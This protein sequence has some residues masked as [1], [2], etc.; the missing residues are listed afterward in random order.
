M[1]S[2]SK[3]L[4]ILEQH[5]IQADD[6]T[7]YTDVQCDRTFWDR[8]LSAFDELNVFARTRK[9]RP[10]EDLSKLLISSRP[11]AHLFPMPDFR[12][13]GG[14]IK[15]H[16]KIKNALQ[17]ALQVSDA[18]IMRA[19]SPIS[20][21]VGGT[22]IKS[23]KPFAVE[24]AM[25]PITAYSRESMKSPL[26]PFVQFFATTSTKRLCRKANGVSYVTE[27]VLQ[28]DFPCTAIREGESD[29][30][31]TAHYSTI[32]LTDDDYSQQEWSE[33]APDT[34]S[35]AHVGKMM[36]LRKG[37]V[38]FIETLALL[39]QRGYQVSGTLIGDGP[40]RPQFE[41]LAWEKGIG[42]EI[43][44]VGWQ[45][46]FRAVQRE[47]QKSMFFLFP[48]YSEGLPRS[49]IEAMASGLLCIGS[50]ADGMVE[51]LDKECI[52][53]RNSAEDY[54][55]MLAGYHSHW[56]QAIAMRDKQFDLSH[57]YNKR[58][59]DTYRTDFYK[60]LRKCGD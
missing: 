9:A 53:E 12:G 17:K 38:I 47:L 25:N 46:G 30:Y 48:S 50:S 60:K 40:M 15:N 13:V 11:E 23:G 21:G 39:K 22:V 3:L 44:F 19:P 8:Y 28:Q 24:M 4:V 36:D 54:A 58:I 45:S 51:L 41:E 27:H 59:L 7:F 20:L 18:V 29:R 57:K 33:F 1:G 34:I 52:S 43:H 5:F 32:N 37:H 31:F 49:I 14:L 56:D 26:R 6:G 35:V 10:G 2:R 55:L 16:G 42:D